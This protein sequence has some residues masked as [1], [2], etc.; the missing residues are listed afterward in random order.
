[1]PKHHE[2]RI[3]P[4][5]PGD[6]FILVADVER[7]PQFLPWCL[8]LHLRGREKDT[9]WAEMTVGYRFVRERFYSKI[10]LDSPH[11]IEIM[12]L[13]GP[14]RHLSN[15]WNFAPGPN[16]CGCRIDFAIDFA[17]KNPLFERLSEALFTTLFTRM[18]AAFERRAATLYATP[19]KQLDTK[20]THT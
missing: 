3:L 13:G 18:V 15:H 12:Y 2:T 17:F 16:G 7:Y 19:A 5:T 10:L 20:G 14:L 9:L 1:M 6:M 4:Y 11:H 8:D